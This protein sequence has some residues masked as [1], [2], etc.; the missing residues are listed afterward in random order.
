[1]SNVDGLKHILYK[2]V[3]RLSLDE[4]KNLLKSYYSDDKKHFYNSPLYKRN[5][6]F[7]DVFIIETLEGVIHVKDEK[8]QEMV[9]LYK[10][11]NMELYNLDVEISAKKKEVIKELIK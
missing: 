8:L 3:D 5:Q 2:E 11:K 1:M 7:T 6:S 10:I 9:K 4:I